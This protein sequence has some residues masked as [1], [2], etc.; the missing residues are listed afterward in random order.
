[1]PATTITHTVREVPG[2]GFQKRAL[3]HDPETGRPICQ[4][5]GGLPFAVPLNKSQRWKR[6]RP[7]PTNFRYGT[8]DS[9]TDFTG[10]ANECPQPLAGHD[11]PRQNENC[12]QMNI[13]IPDGKPPE[14]GW[15][16]FFYICMY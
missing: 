4:R 16:V 11:M 2:R 3:I 14:E 7:L 12:L 5:V 6:A 9:P 10:I 15:P 8:K 1:M 13:F